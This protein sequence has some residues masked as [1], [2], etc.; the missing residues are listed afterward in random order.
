[1]LLSRS[2]WWCR[3]RVG[4][5]L[6]YGRLLLYRRRRPGWL[7]VLCWPF[8]HRGL[9]RRGLGRLGRL[10]LRRLWPCL[11]ARFFW[12]TTAGNPGDQIQFG[13]DSQHLMETGG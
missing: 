7:L 10:G 11:T 8:W 13:L 2:L 12:G 1:M 3:L 5:W 4:R 6:L 9:C